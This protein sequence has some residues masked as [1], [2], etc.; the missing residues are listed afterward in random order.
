LIAAIHLLGKGWVCTT[1]ATDTGTRDA[2]ELLVRP[3]MA[4]TATAQ[5]Y[6]ETVDDDI[7]DYR[8]LKPTE[9]RNEGIIEVPGVFTASQE[10][11]VS[12]VAGYTTIPYILEQ[13]CIV[14][15]KYK[16]DQFKRDLGLKSESF[17]EGA[18]YSYTLQDLKNGLPAE[19]L[20]E[21][22]MFKKRSF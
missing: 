21:L 5:A 3:S 10:Y 17:G 11:F 9:G 2:S 15:V 1:L 18:D 19:L 12:Y 22:D 6:C 4:V 13:I 8:L 7:T 16:Y 20:D 14:L